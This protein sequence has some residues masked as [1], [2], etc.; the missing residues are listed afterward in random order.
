M[1]LAIKHASSNTHYTGMRQKDMLS[2]DAPPLRCLAEQHDWTGNGGQEHSLAL[3]MAW[4]TEQAAQLTLKGSARTTPR[5]VW[6]PTSE[7]L[8]KEEAVIGHSVK[9][10]LVLLLF[11][12]RQASG[13]EVCPN[14]YDLFFLSTAGGSPVEGIKLKCD[15]LKS[16]KVCSTS[17]SEWVWLQMAFHSI[18]ALCVSGLGGM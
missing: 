12:I 13:L 18:A 17:H 2:A 7:A 1:S 5:S 15:N 8:P 14:T 16:L 4:E 9:V 10:V 3:R 11:R 6:K